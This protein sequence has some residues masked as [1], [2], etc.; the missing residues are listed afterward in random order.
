MEKM[1]VP[2][3]KVTS[4]VRMGPRVERAMIYLKTMMQA[5]KG[6]RFHIFSVNRKKWEKVRPS[7]KREESIFIKDKR[8]S[9]IKE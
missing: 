7:Q 5:D 8:R 1:C 4:K 3:T 9:Y 2:G 6:L